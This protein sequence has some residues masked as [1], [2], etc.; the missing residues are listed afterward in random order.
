MP[1]E[2]AFSDTLPFELGRAPRKV[3]NALQKTIF[4]EL[5]NAPEVSAPPRI[6]KL[7]HYKSLWRY[8][9]SDEWR[10]VYSVKPR[11][12]TVVML[13][14]GHRGTIYERLG[15]DTDGAPGNRIIANAPELLE[16]QPT[17]DEI[18]LALL[19]LASQPTLSTR[20]P[21][22][23][24]LPEILTPALLSSWS[25]P[26]SY[27]AILS[28]ARTQDDLWALRGELPEVVLERVLYGLW[29][30]PVEEVIQRPIR[31]TG[32]ADALLEA[33]TGDRSLS[34]FLLKLDDTQKAFVSRF[35]ARTDS[36]P[37]LVKGGPGSG[38]ST[39]AMYCILALQERQQAQL[40]LGAPQRVLYTT[41]TR[42]LT[43]SSELLLRELAAQPG[44]VQIST[45]TM[46]SVVRQNAPSGAQL[47][48]ATKPADWQP[49]MRR[50]ISEC[51]REAKG[52]GFVSDD[53]EFLF[54]EIDWVIFGKDLQSSEAYESTDRRGR[55]RRL[56]AQQ[57]QLI[58]RIHIAFQKALH[59]L[60]LALP[61]ELAALAARSARPTYDYVFI[62][63]A[64]DLKPVHLRLAVG[65]CKSPH[66]IFIT[67]DGNQSIYG[68]G[69]SWR[70]VAEDLR[71]NGRIT[72]LARNYRTTREI[73]EALGDLAPTDGETDPDTLELASVSRGH[74]PYFVKYNNPNAARQ[75]IDAFIKN[76]LHEERIGP[77]CVGVL[78]PTNWQAQQFAQWID[79]RLNPRY[80]K[81]SE[82]DLTHA[83]VKVMTIHASKG[84]QFPI[85]VVAGVQASNATPGTSQL[86]RDDLLAKEQRVLFVGCSRA[87][88]QLMILSNAQ[89]LSPLTSRIS[90]ERWEV[91]EV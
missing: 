68:S 15:Q 33:A 83:G 7:T 58:W 76:A 87:M 48:P 26:E 16:K 45:S 27:I 89:R 51:S 40:A 79:P 18:G 43:T 60:G 37:W 70:S 24:P 77:S 57:K 46:D 3:Q 4:P 1:Y 64:Q 21:A 25:I 2:I 19:Q 44:G 80:M 72:T 28:R 69:I 41:Y 61:S 38:K 88:R 20:A 67:A 62:D 35:K 39:V 86:D 14:L 91:E 53:M 12:H 81:S 73:W 22:S 6:K 11:E 50:C 75:R 71:F 8:R 78:C 47:R 31:L 85:V 17:K 9:V 29:P 32:S 42:A 34:S 23:A 74:P 55:G 30:A 13:M 54:S 59:E 36:G 63:E 84:L 56:S 10:L 90:D 66:G 5:R 82:V 65:L 52:A 49:L